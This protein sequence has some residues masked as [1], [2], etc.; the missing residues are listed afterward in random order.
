MG[1][2]IQG[3]SKKR[4]LLALF[5]G[6]VFGFLTWMCLAPP[7]GLPRWGRFEGPFFFFLTPGIWAGFAASGNIHIASPR[8]A[9]L[10]NFVFYFGLTWIVLS[11][12]K[13]F[14]SR[15]RTIRAG[16]AP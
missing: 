2:D 4:L 11:I 1:D 7:L 9:V 12:W 13:T 15:K 8:V 5:V 16:G 6:G 3:N 14:T 10:G